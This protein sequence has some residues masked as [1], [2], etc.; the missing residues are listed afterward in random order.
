MST[1][2]KSRTLDWIEEG[3]SSPDF[4]AVRAFLAARPEIASVLSEALAV[5]SRYFGENPTITLRVEDDPDE[6]RRSIVAYIRTTLST[7]E[8]LDRLS[9]LKADWWLDATVGMREDIVLSLDFA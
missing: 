7:R 2:T 3:F 6:P 4:A 5:V 9:Q 8:A 1:A